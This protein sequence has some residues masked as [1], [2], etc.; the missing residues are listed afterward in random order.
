MTKTELIAHFMKE[1]EL[2]KPQA[3]KVLEV[4]A[5]TIID[6]AVAGN[7]IT[8]P[9]LGIFTAKKREARMGINPMTKEPVQIQ[10]SIKPAFRAAKSFKDTLKATMGAPA[11]KPAKK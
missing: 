6:A 1:A 2:T 9:G 10:A 3:T 8:I 11:K 4:F 7:K 5:N